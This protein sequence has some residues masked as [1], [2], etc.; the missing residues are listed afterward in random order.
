MDVHRSR[1]I[2][3][4]VILAV[5][6]PLAGLVLT[7]A[8]GDAPFLPGL[9]DKD[10]HPN[11]CVSCHVNVGPNKDY[12]LNAELAKNPKH[13]KI[14]KVVKVVPNDCAI[15]HKEGA[16]VGVLSLIAHKNHYA[17]AKENAFVTNYQGACL[18]CHSLDPATG[19]MTVKSGPKNW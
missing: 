15:C 1:K 5:G 2:L 6:L 17:N 12:R 14:D 11:G 8:G 16:K 7:A 9:T 18:N 4:I 10:D 13:P 19:A 3:T